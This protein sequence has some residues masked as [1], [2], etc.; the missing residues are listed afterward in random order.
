[1]L[2]SRDALPGGS[3]RGSRA[4]VLHVDDAGHVTLESPDV[5]DAFSV[6]AGE[7]SATR[8]AAAFGPTARADGDDHV[9]VPIERLH[10]LGA[11][12]GG[13]DWRAG[14]D[15][16]LA[17]AATKGWVDEAQGLVRAHVDR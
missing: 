1:M 3:S 11:T 6:R 2:T 7:A 9:W 10:A 5:F 17:Y 14:C 16:M 8:I 15:G 4:L 12:H 13:P